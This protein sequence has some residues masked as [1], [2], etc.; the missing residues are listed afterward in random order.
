MFQINNSGVIFDQYAIQEVRYDFEQT[1]SV[2]TD[3]NYIR[4]D[5]DNYII[6]GVA[7]TKVDDVWYRV[8]ETG[9]RYHDGG[10]T[11]EIAGNELSRPVTQ[12]EYEQT[13]NEKKREIYI[14]K[15]ITLTL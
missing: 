6:E 7:W 12:F 15:L 13:E 1:Y 8:T 5:D 10:S 3:I 11:I 14:L 4:I 2:D 9:F